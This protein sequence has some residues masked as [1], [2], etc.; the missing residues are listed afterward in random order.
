MTFS[1][2]KATLLLFVG[3]LAVFAFS[4]WLTLVV[5]YGEL[6]SQFILSLHAA[7][8]GFLFALWVL[9]FY[10]AGLYSKH[11][12]RYKSELWGTILRTQ[13]L[14]I[15]LGVLFFFFTPGIG[16]APKTN[17]AIY[18]FFSLVGIFI[19]RLGVFPRLSRPSLRTGAALVGVGEEVTELIAEVNNNPRYPL[20]FRLVAE[21]LGL[22]EDFATFAKQLQ[23]QNISLL[24]LDAED[25]QLRATLPQLYRLGF[26]GQQYEFADFY[27]VYGEV[28][29]RVPL[30]MLRYNWF[31][32][33]ISLHDGGLY[34]LTKRL[35]DIAGGVLMGVVT[36]I[37][38]PFV[39]LAQRIE[40]PG[41]LFLRQVRLGQHGVPVIAYKFR[42]MLYDDAASREWVN[43]EKSRNRVTR[44]GAFLRK[45]SF[46]EFPQFI[47]ILRG[48]L[49]LVGPRNDIAGL[50]ERLAAEIPYYQARYSVKPGLTGWAQINQQYEQGNISPQS[51]EE[52]KVRLAYDFF[53]IKNRSLALDLVIALKTFKRLFSRVSGW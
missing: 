52:T 37:L 36:L 2:R 51:I 46:D 32:K 44:V 11:V 49:S 27:S 35:I 5:R 30:S 8:F 50:A 41:P 7:S 34:A 39:F 16:I 28:F 40:G 29:D 20:E 3:D 12:I 9:V 4:L 53:Y 48:D 21:P 42:S 1:G 23:E 14:N 22:Q 24:V 33:N 43:E 26:G 6:P 15:T 13:L 31:I 45:T 18:L 19:W 10:M 17:L 25:E 38:I 47:N